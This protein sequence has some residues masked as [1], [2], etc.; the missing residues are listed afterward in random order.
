MEGSL[1]RGLLSLVVIVL[2]LAGCSGSPTSQVANSTYGGCTHFGRSSL[3]PA[4]N[5]NCGAFP[6]AQTV[7]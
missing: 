5:G 2:L 4:G 6:P 1:M 7:F 3:V